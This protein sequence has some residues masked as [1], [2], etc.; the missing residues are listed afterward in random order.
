MK[1][2]VKVGE[3]ITVCKLT[4]A[5]RNI[6]GLL[7]WYMPWKGFRVF[8]HKLRGTVIKK[9][10]E[11][12]YM[13]FI[14]NRRPELITIEDNATITSMCIVLAHDLSM[15]Y[16]DGTETIG[17]TVIKEGAF[18]G[19]NSTI[20]PGVTIGENCIV[21]CGSVVTKDTEPDSVYGGVPARLIK[22]IN[23]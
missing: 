5:I 17:A 10:V 8:F 12:G 20:M 9:N 3:G 21:A 18:I 22:K 23:E 7:A 13:V 16:I 19:M 11:I 4:R 14:D 15:R 1:Q 6:I 2:K